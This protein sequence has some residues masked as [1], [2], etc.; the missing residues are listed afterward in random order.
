MDMGPNQILQRLIELLSQLDPFWEDPFLVVAFQEF[1]A[2]FGDC[3]F[4]MSY[5]VGQALTPLCEFDLPLKFLNVRDNNL[6]V[7]SNGVV[8]GRRERWRRI[9]RRRDERSRPRRQRH[10]QISAIRQR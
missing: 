2:V 7:D 1:S 5:L 3:R 10:A 8:V 4:E 6:R 9:P